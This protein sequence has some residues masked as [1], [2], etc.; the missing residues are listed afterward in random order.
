MN[1]IAFGRSI[2]SVAII[3]ALTV[4]PVV[5]QTAIKMPKNKYKLEDDIKLGQQADAQV[6]QQFPLINNP[7]GKAYIESVGERLVAA[8]PPEFQQPA[9]K[10]RFDLVNASDINAF[11]LPGGPMY[12]NRGMI[13]QAKTEGEM[14]GVMAHE[15][16]HVVLRH[17]TAQQTKQNNPMNQILG[18]GAQIG[19]GIL[20]GQTGAQLGAM[21]A[22]GY[23]MKFSR[24]YE[25]QADILGARIMANAGYDPRDLANMFQTIEKQ[26]GGG[27]GAPEWLSS[28]PNPG[29]RFQKINQEAAMLHINGTP[30]GATPEF[31]KIQEAFRA[32]PPAKSMAQIAKEVESGVRYN[33]DGPAG[34]DTGGTSQGGDA[35]GM[36]GG[37]VALPSTTTRAYSNGPLS[38]QV[39]DNWKEVPSQGSITFAPEGG[40]SN[41]GI[42]HG[43]LLGAKKGTGANLTDTTNQYISE[44]LKGNP[45]LKQVGQAQRVTVAGLQGLGTRLAGQSPTTGK[46]EFVTIVTAPLQNGD[47]FYLAAVVPEAD[48]AKYNTAFRNLI[49]SI[50]LSK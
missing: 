14:A 25:T 34:T 1:R 7:K 13:E 42:T 24:E 38:M 11:A 10:Y 6:R 28:H 47:L 36:F 23:F 3:W 39:P 29:N 50:K 22:Q 20:G 27:G 16:S 8:I 12:V 9:F 5:S 33:N 19:G 4:L 31:R 41:E 35:G 30:R 37:E 32:M 44:L 48:A 17:S 49:N 45:Y 40:F 46:V 15:I 43:V 2:A 26:S 21:A 18:I